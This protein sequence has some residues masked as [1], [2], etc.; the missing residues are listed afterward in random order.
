MHQDDWQS[1]GIPYTFNEMGE[2]DITLTTDIIQVESNVI[3]AGVTFTMMWTNDST[4]TSD[5][6]L[7]WLYSNLFVDE[8]SRY[9][10]T[11]K[12]THGNNA[13]TERAIYLHNA[14][15]GEILSS[16]YSNKFSGEFTL[17]TPDGSP[18]YIRV[19]DES[20]VYNTEVRDNITPIIHIPI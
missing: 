17:I 4:A 3:K 6:I 8:V 7:Q 1:E 18:S 5:S 11:G 14:I 12:V 13:P 19:V 16:G 20:G 15:T 10:I 2:L 9:Q